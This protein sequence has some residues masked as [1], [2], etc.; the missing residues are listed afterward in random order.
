MRARAVALLFVL[1]T[2]CVPVAA[3]QRERLAQ[4]AMQDTR[5]PEGA[6]F[7]AHVRGARE[8][9]LDPAASGGGGCG[10]N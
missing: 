2:G 1:A 5:L 6:A 8:S 7:D 3:W 4:P 10:C 9:A